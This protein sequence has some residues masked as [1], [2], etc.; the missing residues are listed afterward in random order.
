[1]S[2]KDTEKILVESLLS[3]SEKEG[4]SIGKPQNIQKLTGDAS[5]RAYYRVQAQEGSFV[6]CLDNPLLN[7]QDRNEFVEVQKVL[8]QEKIRVPFIKHS[9][10]SKGYILEEDLGDQTLLNRLSLIESK[11]EEFELYQ[12]AIDEMSKMHR[13]DSSKYQNQT[14]SQISF[15]TQKLNQEIEL[16]LEYF[17]EGFL[18]AS[19]T[20][21]EESYVRQRFFDL[22]Q[23][24]SF[25]KKVFTHRDYHSRN[26][27]IKN[28][29]MIIIDFQ[30]C[31]QG[32][33]QYDLVSLLDDCYY[34]LDQENVEK[35]KRYYF[36]HF[37]LVEE[38]QQ[39]Y[40]RFEYLYDLMKIQ[41][42][43]KALGTF[44]YIYDLRSDERYLKYIGFA[45]E[46]LRSTFLRYPEFN[47][48]RAILSTAY[49]D[50]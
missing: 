22:C 46:K 28:E 39:S 24:L 6:V 3:L 34:Q 4:I 41:R 12:N 25:E 15:D 18:K 23:K 36:D 10:L 48:L 2:K 9:L 42:V 21:S 50:A 7:D 45:F 16:S 20:E 35:L 47:K 31:R 37:K 17:L 27:M 13:I 33:P 19:L 38:Y 30:D 40:S 14:F 43:F 44:S 5:T 26:I 32:L 8:L 11:E 29:E 1:M 49:Y